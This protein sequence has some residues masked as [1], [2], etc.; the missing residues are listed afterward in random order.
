MRN[1]AIK[2]TIGLP[3]YN[4]ERYLENTLNSLLNQTYKD[5]RIIISDNAS[6]DNTSKICKNFQKKDTRI[7]YLR[8]KENIGASGNYL[9][10][11]TN[12]KT[13]F[14]MWASHDDLWEPTFIEKL[15]KILERD[16]RIVLAF[17]NYDF[18]LGD[19]T[20]NRLLNN[21]QLKKLESENINT[22]IKNLLLKP[23]ANILYGIYRT[24][25]LKKV[26]GFKRLFE[27]AWNHDNL[28]LLSLSLFGSF[29]YYPEI[30]FHKRKFLIEKDSGKKVIFPIHKYKEKFLRINKFHNEQRKIILRAD[31]NV[32]KRIF[33]TFITYF[34]QFRNLYSI[35]YKVI[36]MKS[37]SH[38]VNVSFYF[39][40]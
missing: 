30:L 25:P 12:A 11:L 17:S 32:F 1:Q 34:I 15:I 8:N 33:L 9:K 36:K 16:D 20:N 18:I 35:L 4:G 31:L 29:K 3:V 37:N 22:R 39:K 24:S 10:V 21:S 28:M 7:I 2:V 23:D 26:G 14:F 13:P 6:T 40:K 38:L 27:D 5:F 19:D